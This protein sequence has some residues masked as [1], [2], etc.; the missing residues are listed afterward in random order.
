LKTFILDTNVLL[1]DATSLEVF[2]NNEVVIPLAVLDEL[3]TAKMHF[4]EVGRNARTV[5]RT[6]DKLRGMG[7]LSGGVEIN[8]S[9]IR[10]ELNHSGN[11]PEGLSVEKADNRII[12]TA[13]GLQKLG[14]MVI[15]VSKDINLRVKC[16]VLGLE[17]Q[18][19]EKD[20][21]A[22]DLDTIYGGV[23]TLFVPSSTINDLYK[24]G[25]VSIETEAY[26]NQF[27]ILKSNEK[28]SHSGITRFKG[29]EFRLCNFP[30]ELWSIIPRN[31]EQKMAME[32]LMDPSIKLV[33]LIGKAG[34]G[35]TLIA[36]ASAL[37]HVVNEHKLYNRILLSRPIQPMGKDLGFLPGPQP[38]DA[39][40][41]T[42]DGWT[43]MGELKVGQQVISRDGFPT[44][45]TGIYP[46]GLKAVY[47]VITT[48]DR[49]TECCEDHLWY[50]ETAE[51]RKRKKTG[52]VKNTKEII[53]TIKDKNNKINHRLPKNEIVHFNNFALP[54]PPY[55]M[56]VL[57]GEG[58][59][60]DH[61]DVSNINKE[62]LERVK[63]ELNVLG[64]TIEYDNKKPEVAN[65]NIKRIFN[66]YNKTAKRICV[67]NLDNGEEKIFTRIGEAV[68]ALGLTKNRLEK[69]C[70]NSE[71]ENGQKFSFMQPSNRWVNP[72][73]EILY[74][75]GMLGMKA[76]QKFIPSDYIYKASVEDRIALLQ[77]LMDS[78]GTIKET[79]ESSFATTSKQLAEDLI[80]L[81]RSLGGQANLHWRDR[82]LQIN[83]IIKG[84]E[85]ISKHISYEFDISFSNNIIPFYISEKSKHIKPR[86]YLHGIWIKAIKFVGY[87]EVQCIMIENPEHLYITDDY[88]V[89]HNT[90]EEKLQ[91]WMQPIYD[92][93]ELLLGAD[94]NMI[95]MYKEQGIIHV[96]PLTYIRGRSIPNSFIILDEAQNLSLHEIKT[97]IT[98][99]GENSKIVLNGDI[100]QLDRMELDF[101]SNG[102]T[103]VVEKFKEY[104]IAGHI[105]LRKGERS[106]LATLASEIL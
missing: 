21:I 11:V 73:K 15:V 16:D 4:D 69:L 64:C 96:E 49:E 66:D 8:G 46:K 27:F 56:G 74:N 29:G 40:I 48:D 80:S 36:A 99:L 13:L 58:T 5:I 83:G 45:I 72:I 18:D 44:K 31:A 12:S 90:I 101:S 60:G 78:E 10:V 34:S 24:N 87:K 42:P 41:L 33:T 106:E 104:P 97:I 23:K 22:K 9:I 43:T 1:H 37:H 53:L 103:H 89:T 65:F 82:R 51:N 59:F 17:A 54:I 52:S 94:Y 61:V 62:L 26:P 100:D 91:P 47:K 6:L 32:L 79:G 57:I 92:N 86:K 50:T 35:K 55:T 38:L 84:R 81:V 19:Y 30:K 70:R 71:T 14:K 63:K 3:D 102:L 25:K 7:S 28:E 67:K 39:K 2:G 93:L 76:P 88:I 68:V 85:I 105:T 98:R 95:D 75:Y 77:G 20:K